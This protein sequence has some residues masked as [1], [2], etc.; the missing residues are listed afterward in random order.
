MDPPPGLSV[1]D[2][3]YFIW[4]RNTSAQTWFV[5]RPLRSR[6][7]GEVFFDFAKRRQSRDGSFQGALSISLRPSYFDAFFQ[8]Q[9][10]EEPG[11][12]LSMYRSDGAMISRF[13]PAPAG[14]PEVLS[15][16]SG[17][18]AA[19]RGG[20]ASGQLQGLSTIDG[21]YR[22]VAY[23]QISE[24]P[25][26]AVATAS[27]N[28]LLAPWRSSI[29]TLSAFTLPLS[30]GL[31]LLCWFA[32]RRVRS[33]HAIALAH[34]DQ[35]E[36][37]LRAEEGLRQAQKMEALGRLTG[38]VAHDFNNV[39]MVVQSGAALARQLE[40]RGQPIQ[41][42]LS[43]IERAVTNGAQLTRQLLAVA[44][45][46]PLQVSTVCLAEVMPELAQ[47]MHSTLGSSV[48]IDVDVEDPRLCVTVDQAE[49]ELALINLCINA[50]DA[51]PEGGKIGIAA[52]HALPPP[53][54]PADSA[55]LRL[56]VRDN[57]LGIPEQ[58]LDRI[59]EPFFT[60]KELGK[61]TGLGLS[62]VQSFAVQASGHLEISSTVGVGTEVAILLPCKMGERATPAPSPEPPVSLRATVML[63]EDNDDIAE[64][65]G[66]ILTAAGAQVLRRSSA[67]DA[68]RILGD[69]PRP[70]VV[71]SDM[72]MPGS[73]NGLDLAATLAA[74]TPPIPVVLMTGYT[75]R[76]QEAVQAGFQIVAKPAP[77]SVLVTAL[78]NALA[79]ARQEQQA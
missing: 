32:I 31:A 77:P 70:D 66:A 65:I 57:G 8:Q 47:L 76:L 74:M 59:T 54:A 37:R 79:R 45:R 39:L 18:L 26:Y 6:T 41:T 73:T 27:R 60:T 30:I 72:Q 34:Q 53:G 21:D 23:R 40:R 62:Q 46:Q 7:T 28:V 17:L 20:T 63:V 2:R 14:A 13:P 38:G 24:L 9:V 44:R 10:A 68:L 48:Q 56:S 42:A 52:H 5:S 64:A 69:A 29:L 51:M 49:L 75:D 61:G 11:F 19:M 43:T 78:A 71:L 67:D 36:Q 35:Y 58:L 33:E 12:T 16:A 22:Y 4:A 25:L 55:W 50:R 15:S 1:S 3:E